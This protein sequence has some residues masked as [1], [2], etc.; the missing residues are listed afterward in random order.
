ML[1]A[2]LA[3]Y[4]GISLLGWVFTSIGVIFLALI[5]GRLA[6]STSGAGGPY[7]YTRQAFGDFAGYLV[8]WSYWVS[9][10]MAVTAV[11]VAFSGYLGVMVPSLGDSKLTQSLIAFAAIWGLTVVNIMGVSRAASLQLVLTLLKIIPLLVIIG[12]GV[13]MG[14]LET[15]PA[16]N[17]KTVS[18]TSGIASTALLT[19]WAFIG[20]EAAV[21]PAGDVIDPKRTI[22]RAVV[23]A[24]LTVAIIYILVT[25]AVMM[26]VPS[27]ILASS[28]APFVDA[29]KK[30]GPWGAAFIGIGALLSTAGSLN[31]NILVAGQMPMAV[32]DD[33]LAPAILAQKNKGNAPVF[34]LIVSSI[35]ASAL[36]ALNLTD[37]L[38]EVF[39]FLISIS[40]LCVLTPYT[41]CAL[42]EI[43]RSHKSA[44]GWT[45][46]AGLTVAYMIIAAA[47]SGIKVLL[48][49]LFLMA[50][51]LPFYFLF[52]KPTVGN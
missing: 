22:P 14:S 27:D 5:L 47:G 13:F 37:N 2:V 46:I 9:V 15:M 49:G 18:I 12:L 4:G 48:L 39:T 50:V 33:G 3:P 30:L 31:G 25:I 1:P 28:E 7:A 16:F 44:A 10:T 51:G 45:L 6:Q 11:A 17:P 32:A 42:A 29:A 24:A 41:A 19:M 26:L 35:M 43:K 52:K 34:S 23:S 8:G 38:I 40:T 36:L 21:I 20:A